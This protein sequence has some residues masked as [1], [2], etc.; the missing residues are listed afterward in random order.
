VLSAMKVMMASVKSAQAPRIL[1][2][3]V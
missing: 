2:D 3:F 1:S